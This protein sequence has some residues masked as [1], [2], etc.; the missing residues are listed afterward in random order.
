MYTCVLSVYSNMIDP[1]QQMYLREVDGDVFEQADY[2][3]YPQC[4]FLTF[5]I[6]PRQRGTVLSSN[7]MIGYLC[8]F[9]RENERVGFAVSTCKCEYW[10]TNAMQLV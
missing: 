2:N 5:G 1:S 8:V 9:D 6:R 7:L 3:C 10:N 4:T